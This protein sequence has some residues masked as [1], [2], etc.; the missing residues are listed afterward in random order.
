MFF[1]SEGWDEIA[2]KCLRKY[3]RLVDNLN[4]ERDKANGVYCIHKKLGHV[5]RGLN[6]HI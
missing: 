3:E 5:K 4:I 6:E 2:Y 1:I